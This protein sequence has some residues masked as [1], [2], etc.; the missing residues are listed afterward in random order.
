MKKITKFFEWNNNKLFDF[1]GLD[2]DIP[3]N[4]KEN[5]FTGIP[6][7]LYY[8]ALGIVIMCIAI[9]LIIPIFISSLL[10]II[11]YFIKKY[12]KYVENKKLIK[13]QKIRFNVIKNIIYNNIEKINKE[14]NY[15]LKI[16]K[17]F[18]NNIKRELLLKEILYNASLEE[19]IKYVFNGCLSKMSFYTVEA[20][21]LNL[22]NQQCHRLARRSI[23]DTFAI[24]KYYYPETTFN[25]FLK[26]IVILINNKE[27]HISK[28]KDIGKYV[29]Y[30]K[31]MSGF[32]NFEKPIEFFNDSIT[33]DDLI[34]YY[35]Y[36]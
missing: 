19:I 12:N 25:D 6:L 13:Q 23:L 11:Y 2:H 7:L 24:I 1:K 14:F 20:D 33:F 32:N 21:E 10:D 36:E 27:L 15:Q 34:L 4:F 28:C 16:V 17:I 8:I 31:R 29:L 18:P 35:K 26:T 5:H 30:T 3:E 22:D 9:S